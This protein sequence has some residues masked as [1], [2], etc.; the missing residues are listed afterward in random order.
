LVDTLKIVFPKTY[1]YLISNI[2]TLYKKHTFIL[3]KW[4][5]ETYLGMSEKWLENTVKFCHYEFNKR[6]KNPI[7][8][9][10]REEFAKIFATI[11]KI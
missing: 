1:A 5:I 11:F 10:C 7:F 9:S 2:D 3:K 8:D 4:D 6:L